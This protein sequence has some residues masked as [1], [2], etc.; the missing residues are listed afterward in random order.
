MTPVKTEVVGVRF[1]LSPLGS[2]RSPNLA[3]KEG[4]IIGGSL[5]PKSVR[6]RFDGNK[7]PK[8]LHRDYIELILSKPE[9]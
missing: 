9:R 6:V 5:Y 2:R 7:S 1:K 4:V 8:T 3:G